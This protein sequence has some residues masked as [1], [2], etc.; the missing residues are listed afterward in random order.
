M[1]RG[2]KLAISVATGLVATLLAFGY[3]SSVRAGA[4]RER[5]EVLAAYGGELVSVCVATRDIDA[6]ET[7]DESNVQIEEWVA[8]L[9]PADAVTSMRDVAGKHAT[10]TIPARA[11]LCP[12]YFEVRDGALDVPDGF[13]A[14]SVPV[15]SAHAVGGAIAS[16]D[17]VDVYLSGSGVA[18][19]LCHARVLTCSNQGNDAADLSWVTLAVEPDCVA[20]LLSAMSSGSISVVVPGEG[21]YEAEAIQSSRGDDEDE[22]AGSSDDAAD[23]DAGEEETDGEREADEERVPDD[24]EASDSAEADSSDQT[25]EQRDGDDA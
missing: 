12:A 18:S 8:S 7:L 22:D 16:G 2:V 19:V 4:E 10:S 17:E 1:K 14:V 5:Q 24:D 3:G 11:V 9:L 21:V 6:G 13:I 20:E 15:D 25:A 23:S